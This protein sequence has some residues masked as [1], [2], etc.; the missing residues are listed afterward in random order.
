MWFFRMCDALH[1]DSEI[2][3]SIRSPEEDGTMHK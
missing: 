2:G 1:V 3:V